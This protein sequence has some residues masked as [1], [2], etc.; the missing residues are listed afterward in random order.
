MRTHSHTRAENKQGNAL[1]FKNAKQRILKSCKGKISTPIQ[2]QKP[3]NN[4]TPFVSSSQIQEIME[5]YISR[6]CEGEKL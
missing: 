3:Q 1:I 2:R 4:L 6:I 5:R